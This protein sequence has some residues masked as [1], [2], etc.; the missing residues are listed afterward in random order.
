[1]N[2]QLAGVLVTLGVVLCGACGDDPSPTAP[3]PS[4]T[5]TALNVAGS[6]AGGTSFQLTA[7]AQLSDGKS[8]DV[9]GMASWSSSNPQIATVAN[10]LVTVS[11]SGEVDVRATYQNVSGGIHLVVTPLP[12]SSLTISGATADDRFQL[13]ATARLT[14]GSTQNVTS[15]AAWESSNP[16]VATVSSTGFVTVVS[17]GETDVRATYRGISTSQRLT[18][19]AATGFTLTGT[20]QEVAPTV[21]PIAGA[22]VRILGS[23]MAPT[24]T[25][26]NGT[27]SFSGVPAERLLIEVS[28]AGY[29]VAEK[30]VTISRDTQLTIDLYPTP[31]QDSSGATATARC[32]DGSWSWA[33]TTAA[34]CPSNGGVAYTVCPGVL[35]GL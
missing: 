30:D 19:V 7:M 16:L 2:R 9:T 11:G 13:T 29:V 14:D 10:G 35:C 25:G 18:V 4:A 15:L 8:Q 6:G 3:S 23:G 12:I 22:S 5:V 34:A 28:Q 31:P 20:V 26:P 21:R 27:F 32:K 24:T 33:G 1:M 17:S